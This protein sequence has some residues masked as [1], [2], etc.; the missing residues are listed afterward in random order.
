LLLQF[1]VDSPEDL[2]SVAAVSR[3][4]DVIE[5]GTPLLKRFGLSA[6]STV[7]A[8]AGGRP[9]LADTKT[10]D[11][12]GTE[13]RM[14]FDAGAHFVTVLAC[15]SDATLQAACQ[16]ASPQRAGTYIV[17]DAMNYADVG[18]LLQRRHPREV[19]YVLLHVSHDTLVAG[20]AEEQA[21]EPPESRTVP[22]ALAG[23]ITENT[24]QRAIEQSASL[25]VVGSA[26]AQASNP[27]EMAKRLRG[28]IPQAG[29]G[30][31]G[32]FGDGRRG[33]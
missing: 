8:L 7:R 31:P 16:E 23:G 12:G 32:E 20:V 24:I 4:V 14:M 25:V 26:I 13:A 19:G 22:I 6:I 30:W 5:V 2:A 15:S 21:L 9:V 18:G 17:I 11:G 28:L 1:A 29:T 27:A 10:M 3:W 33:L